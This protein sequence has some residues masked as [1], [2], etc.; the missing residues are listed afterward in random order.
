MDLRDPDTY[1]RVRITLEAE[2]GAASLRTFVRLAWPEVEPN[3]LRWSWHM[4]ALCAHLEAVSRGE[5][6]NLVI[7]VPPGASKSL[8]VS[9]LWPA[10]DWITHPTRRFLAAT[11]AQELSDKNAKLHRDLVLSEW[12]QARWGDRVRIGSSDVAKV[13]EF[14]LESKGWRISTS[15]GGRATGLHADIHVGDDLAKAQDAQGRAYVDPVAIEKANGFWFDTMATRR[16][17]AATLARVMVAQ[18][19]HHDD[20]PGKC[21]ERGYTALVLPMEYDPAR[22]CRTSV[23]WTAPGA[24]EPTRFEDPRTEKGELL[25]PGRFPREV[26][27]ADKKTLG[28]ITNEAQNNQN[29]TPREG[30]IFKNAGRNRWS[31]LPTANIVKIVTVDCAF[32]DTAK[33]DFVAIQVWLRHGQNFY[34]VERHLDRMGITA[35]IGRILEVHARHPRAAVHVED[36][37][38][39]PAVVEILKSEIPGVCEWS[40]GQDSKESRA[41]AVA[42]LVDSGNVWF[43]PDSEAPWIGEYL[44]TLGRFPLVKHD[45]DV[46]ATTMALDI[47]YVPRMASYAAMVAKLKGGT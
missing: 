33:S 47:L 21:I 43:P 17:D 34:L 16:A 10:W 18:R 35:T 29:P 7:C 20:T 3:A 13:R 11:Y 32:K 5:I 46:D 27:E 39:G 6:K 9:T 28:P 2:E 12:Y 24:T 45:D 22:P 41:Q 30:V 26:V 31:V 1:A 15:V 42:H 25:I 44:A 36:K 14:R 19:L 23:W 38:N 37:A 8:I 4:D 40:P